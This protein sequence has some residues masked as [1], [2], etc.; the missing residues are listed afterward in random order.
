MSIVMYCR[1]LRAEDRL[2][3]GGCRKL[4]VLCREYFGDKFKIGHDRFCDVLRSNGLLQ[5][6][7][8][9]LVS[10][11][12]AGD[13]RTAGGSPDGAGLLPEPPHQH[14]VAHPPL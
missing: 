14:Q 6:L 2:P 10:E 4:I 12:D 5:P 3:K 8:H 1:W 9:R 13:G 11:P 7:Y